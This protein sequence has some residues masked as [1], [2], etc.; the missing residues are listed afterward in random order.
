MSPP[1]ED[2]LVRDLRAGSHAP[3][4]HLV[5]RYHHGLVRLAR[6]FVASHAVAEEVVQE[7]W[8]AVLEGIGRFEG[9]S[10]L[11]SWIY[12]IL[13]NRARSRGLREAR[14]LPFTAT[15]SSQP[16]AGP[17][18]EVESFGPR[19]RWSFQAASPASP[20]QAMADRETNDL[21]L[22]G[23]TE[24][25]PK[26]GAVVYLRDVR[27][28]TAQEVCEAMDI[29]DV[30]QRVLLHRGRSQLREKILPGLDEAPSNSTPGSH[31]RGT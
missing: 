28:W 21:V 23:L 7:T 6:R 15:R 17:V 27:H 9:R 4:D 5:E 11:K 8:I 30:Y 2:V 22:R 19:A 16:D 18:P 10:S 13:L 3:F 29:S 31:S 25:P 14:V 12:R 26:Q 1:P 20:E 24:I